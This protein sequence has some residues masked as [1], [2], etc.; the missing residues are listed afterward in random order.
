ML[1]C[2]MATFYDR[3]LAAVE[4]RTL[5]TW[6]DELLGDLSGV[7]V[8]LGSGTGI[9]LSRY[10]GG[11]AS[12]VLTEPDAHMRRKLTRRLSTH[13]A[14]ER[15]TLLDAPAE[16]LPME[17]ASVDVVVSTLVLCTVPDPVAALAEVRRVLRPDGRLLFIEHVAAPPDSSAARWQA[18]LEPVW[19]LFAGGCRLTRPTGRLLE[20]AGFTTD[21]LQAGVLSPAPW[22]IQP[23]IRGVARVR[24]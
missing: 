1:C 22:F 10:P 21:T 3:A 4:A 12:L 24:P 9:N 11:A 20:E 7:V 2:L 23:A 19:G 6:R 18:R 16:S 14:P 17:D 15:I 13:P 8:E 5:G